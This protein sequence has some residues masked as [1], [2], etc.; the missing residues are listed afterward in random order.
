MVLHWIIALLIVLNF[1]AVWVAEDMPRPER[2]QIMA[3]HKS[4][5]LTVLALSL[6]RLGWRFTHRSPPLQRRLQPWEQTLA[7]T[8]HTLFYVLMIGLPLSGWAM[9]SSG[10]PVRVFGLFAVPAL[11]VSTSEAAGDRFFSVHETLAWGMLALLA[12]HVAGALK[13]H[14]IDRDGALGRMVPFLRAPRA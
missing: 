2:M 1:V 8:V 14:F 3:N 4:I 10:G 5:G 11:P 7:R 9:V 6:V 13:H 12:L